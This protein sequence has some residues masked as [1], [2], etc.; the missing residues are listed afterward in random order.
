MK[1]LDH[2]LIPILKENHFAAMRVNWDDKVDNLMELAREINIG[3]DSMVFLD[4]D[5]VNRAF[6]KNRLPEVEVPDLPPDSSR[7]ARFLLSLPYFNSEAITDEDKMRGNLYV[8]ERLRKGAEKAYGKKE[9]FLKDLG[10]ELEV[11]LD[12][13]SSVARLAQLTEKTNQFNVNKKPLSEDEVREL[14]DHPDYK[15]F[16][17]RVSDRF[18]DYGITNLAVAKKRDGPWNL[19]YFLMSCRSI[20][21]GIEDAFLSF[22]GDVAR[23]DGANQLS[24]DFT[25][26][27]KNKPAL[28]FVNKHFGGKVARLADIGNI[29]KPE[30]IMIKNG[31]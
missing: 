13:Y 22:I 20:G 3:L 24:I 12:D 23:K 16:Y 10:L 28:E 7:Y 4:D 17:A 27:E 1:L 19:K 8:T 2:Y 31:K 15:V 6:V 9:D 26:T 5:P 29:K 14:I 21:R 18:G 11:F 30:W 25:E